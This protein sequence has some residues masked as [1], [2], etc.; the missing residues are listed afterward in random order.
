MAII[1][2]IPHITSN[3]TAENP[4][5]D[6]S[7]CNTQRFLELGI[8][9]LTVQLSAGVSRSNLS[10]LTSNELNKFPNGNSN[11]NVFEYR[12]LLLLFASS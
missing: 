8:R 6:I 5:T 2:T 3:N 1:W 4:S 12:V 9:F 10:C 7:V 11:C